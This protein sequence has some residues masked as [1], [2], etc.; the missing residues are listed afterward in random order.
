MLQG[1]A[2][3]HLVSL[4]THPNVAYFAVEFGNFE[5]PGSTDMTEKEG[6]CRKCPVAEWHLAK[7][8]R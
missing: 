2:R 1:L 8:H 6:R 3:L 4:S 7:G 5:F